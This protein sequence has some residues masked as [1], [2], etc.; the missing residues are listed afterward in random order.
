MSSIVS[1]QRA[2]YTGG[3]TNEIDRGKPKLGVRFVRRFPGAAARQV[4]TGHG[5]LAP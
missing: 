1:N 2:S 4:V 3:Y 5:F